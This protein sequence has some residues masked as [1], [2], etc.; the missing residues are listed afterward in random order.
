MIESSNFVFLFPKTTWAFNALPSPQEMNSRLNQRTSHGS[1]VSVKH[2]WKLNS[3]LQWV[4]FS[5]YS[6]HIQVPL[7]KRR[8]VFV[9]LCLSALNFPFLWMQRKKLLFAVAALLCLCSCASLWHPAWSSAAHVCANLY[10]AWLATER[11][12]IH[13]LFCCCHLLVVF[14]LCRFCLMFGIS[15]Q[16]PCLL[17]RLQ[18]TWYFLR[19]V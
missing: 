13:L 11:A 18:I 10:R 12:S 8:S 15:G 1:S 17:I 9:V 7:L 19:T 6:V 14:C 16:E 2:C 5:Y 3:F 4:L